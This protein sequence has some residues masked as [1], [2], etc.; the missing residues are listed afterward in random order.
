MFRGFHSGVIKGSVVMQ[1]IIPEE[2]NCD[3]VT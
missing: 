2:W 3:T 1:C